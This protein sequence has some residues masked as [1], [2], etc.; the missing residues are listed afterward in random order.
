MKTKVFILAS[1]EQVR[2][3][4]SELKQ[5]LI[6]KGQS[7]IR[8]IQKQFEIYYPVWGI[9]C[10]EEITG[11]V[12]EFITPEKHRW[13]VETL[14]STA[15]YWTDRTIVL[16]GDVIFTENAVDKIV[17]YKGDFQIFADGG[18]IFAL[19]FT[20]KVGVLNAIDKAI[21]HAK[22][23]GRGKLWEL[24]RAYCGIDLD[25]H[26]IDENLRTLITDNTMDIDCLHDYKLAKLRFK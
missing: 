7:I 21:K 13:T 19:S 25:S 11:E 8:R 3:E 26:E 14:K 24:Y 1:G 6:L 17:M 16:L 2:F 15:K 12:C 4:G 10:H 23:G 18:E 9:T 5:L 20:D 22:N